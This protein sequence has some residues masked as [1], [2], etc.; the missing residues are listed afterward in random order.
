MKDRGCGLSD[1]VN[2]SGLSAVPTQQKL[3]IY[4]NDA[5]SSIV[6]HRRMHACNITRLHLDLHLGIMIQHPTNQFPARS[7]VVVATTSNEQAT[8]TRPRSGLG[9]ATRLALPLQL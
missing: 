7:L 4:V 5:V 9:L 2:T 3:V 8:P 1:A 6:H